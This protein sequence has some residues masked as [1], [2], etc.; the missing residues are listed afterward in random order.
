MAT[1]IGFIAGGA[2]SSSARDGADDGPGISDR[3]RCR[4][5]S[6]GLALVAA[7]PRERSIGRIVLESRFRGR[8]EG[9]IHR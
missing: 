9:N 8:V 6:L 7:M 4:P 2:T 1:G 5:R 3:L